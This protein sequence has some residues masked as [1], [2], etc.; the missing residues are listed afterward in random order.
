MAE[1]LLLSRLHA[2]AAHVSAQHH[3]DPWAILDLDPR[4]A[5]DPG[6]IRKAFHALSLCSALLAVICMH[7]SP[8]LPPGASTYSMPRAAMS[9][10]TVCRVP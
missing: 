1:E 8:S 2:A 9:H 5:S 4:A 10:S 3:G 7:H 6:H